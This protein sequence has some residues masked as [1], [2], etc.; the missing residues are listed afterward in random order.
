MCISIQRLHIII[1]I[2]DVFL[3]LGT[4]IQSTKQLPSPTYSCLIEVSDFVI[5]G[6]KTRNRT[7][8]VKTLHL[9][10]NKASIILLPT[11]TCPIWWHYSKHKNYFVSIRIQKVVSN[12][13]LCTVIKR[14]KMYGERYHRT[15]IIHDINSF[16]NSLRRL[17]HLFSFF[18][19]LFTIISYKKGYDK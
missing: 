18:S 10:H 7:K 15:T 16:R 12:N 3:L 9:R 6:Y 8:I 5:T 13:V 17:F 14:L 2:H 11:V 4:S 19:H 1:T